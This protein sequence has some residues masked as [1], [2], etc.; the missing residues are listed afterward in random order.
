MPE[1]Y[2]QQSE[3]P[4]EPKEVRCVGRGGAQEERQR[5]GQTRTDND[6]RR[7]QALLFAPFVC[8]RSAAPGLVVGRGSLS[9]YRMR[10]SAVPGQ[11][12]APAAAELFPD[13]IIDVARGVA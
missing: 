7:T 12:P 11:Y 9:Q 6:E 13:T 2:A 3:G 10:S 5:H 1:P 4:D 8:P